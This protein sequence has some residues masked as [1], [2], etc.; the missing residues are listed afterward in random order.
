MAHQRNLYRSLHFLHLALCVAVFCPI[1][2]TPSGRSTHFPQDDISI[3]PLADNNS[4]LVSSART[5]SMLGLLVTK[6]SMA[7]LNGNAFQ[8]AA[9][10]LLL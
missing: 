1:S 9:L 8:M 10:W 3:L 2:D 5:F 4:Q 6:L 7:Q